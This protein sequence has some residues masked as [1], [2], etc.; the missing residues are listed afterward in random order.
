[1]PFHG[2]FFADV[3]HKQAVRVA[4]L[5]VLFHG[6][7]SAGAAANE[8]EEPG[9]RAALVRVHLPLVGNADQALQSTLQ[10]T[11]DRLIAAARQRNDPRRPLLVLQLDP[12]MYRDAI[13]ARSQ[14]ERVFALA[15]FLCS[16]QMAGIRTIAFV[17][18]SIQGHDV[19]LTMAC[20][21]VIMAP[22]AMIGESGTDGTAEET[23]QQTVIAAYRE[24][25]EARRTLPVALA[26]GMID[27][28]AEVLQV[29]TEEGIDFV[30]RNN[31][32]EFSR[33]R[34][35]VKQD[36]L[37]PAGTLAQFSGRE[38][39][40][41]GFVK[42]L[43][44]QRAEVAAALEVPVQSLEEDD[45]LANQWR[46]V[47]IDVR[48][49]ITAQIASRLE[50]LLGT[51]MEQNKANWIGV[52]IESAGGDLE[53]SLRLA[54]TLARLDPNSV[55]TVAY[56]PSEAAGGA[57]L[58]ALACDQLVMHST[59]RL[60][61]GASAEQSSATELD[62]AVSTI[63]QSLAPQTE[64]SWSL[65]AAMIDPGIELMEYHNKATGEMRL[66]SREEAAAW[67]NPTDWQQRQTLQEGN[68][69]MALLKLD[70]LRA[71]QL[72]VAWRTVEGFD[73]LKK[74]YGLQE[75]PPALKP[76]LAL[77][78]VE[79]LASPEFAVML[80]M[81]GFAGIYFEVRTPGLGV[82]AFIGS[83]GFLL[84]FWSQYLNGTAG[85]LEVL[86]F[87]VGLCFILLEIFVLPGFGVFGLGGAAMVIASV[88]LASL[89]F[90]RP[91]SES[92]VEE[93]ARSVGMVA[94]AGVGVMA[95]TII[96]R[97]Y[98]P[99]AP[100]FRRMVLAPDA[101]EEQALLDHREA[102]ADFSGLLGTRGVAYTDLR[103]AGKA[104]IDH[105]LIDVIAES[106]PLDRG[107]PL[108]VVEARANRV[109][110]K[111][112]VVRSDNLPEPPQAS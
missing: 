6:L 78:L 54:S 61:S 37:I 21:E 76:N 20:E 42:Y 43:A 83:L 107:T 55:R 49:K 53:S 75:D 28:T 101:P 39:R 26:V 29:E 11:S 40:E 36:V 96:S 94:I 102:L 74:I 95:L 63:R 32:E 103:P 19:L 15:R 97:R 59:A 35:I 69:P 3:H 88:V 112:I 64:R 108:V 9:D 99:Q 84:Y 58:V 18:R 47:L 60:V 110:V 14:F 50:T 67:P 41:F 71:Q 31:F 93:L 81:I 34:E 68:D 56:V 13:G 24:I 87:F 106:E 89:T 25:A 17:P 65:L 16:R 80:L 12:P 105:E 104:E 44:S 7:A 38:G 1:M 85:W 79:A 92:D 82:G 98:L 57:A 23:I 22:E 66:M 4:W 77:E 33:G 46:P 111:R 70:G 8:T 51:A 109:V 72:G 90:I 73:Q 5:I 2:F 30:L 27:A 91:H 62:A 45:A 48:G 86:L 100:L 10:R 52:R